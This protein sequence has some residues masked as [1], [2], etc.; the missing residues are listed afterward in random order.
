MTIFWTA[1][2]KLKPQEI[3]DYY[4]YEVSFEVAENIA[5]QIVKETLMLLNSPKIG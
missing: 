2:V 3:Y 1:L 4:F 5:S